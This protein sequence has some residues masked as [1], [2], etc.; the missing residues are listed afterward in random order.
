MWPK[1]I[2]DLKQSVDAEEKLK[3]LIAEKS[4]RYLEDYLKEVE[5]R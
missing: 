1:E 3:Q 5:G 4:K 2:F